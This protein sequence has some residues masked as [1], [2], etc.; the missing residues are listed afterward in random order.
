MGCSEDM[1]LTPQT[2]KNWRTSWQTPWRSPKIPE[3]IRPSVEEMQLQRALTHVP[4]I[5]LVGIFNLVAVMILSAHEGVETIY[6]AWMGLLAVGG[7]GRMIIWIRYPKIPNQQSKRTKY[8][9]I[10]PS[11]RLVSSR[12]SASGR[13]I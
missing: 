7:L 8:S 3:A 13:Y 10:C 5:Y 9:E 6:Y 11:L 12:F 1:V 4:M 2:E